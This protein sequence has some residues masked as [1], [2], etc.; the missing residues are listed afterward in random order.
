MLKYCYN[1]QEMEDKMEYLI[2]GNYLMLKIDENFASMT[3]EEIFHYFCL[4]KKAIHLL[5]QYKQYFLNNQYVPM[6]TIVKQGDWLKIS[7]FETG[8]D[9][10]PQ[11]FSLDIVYEDDFL[12]VVNKPCHVIIYPEDKTGSN[13]LCN[14]VAN[15][16]LE[17]D[18]YYPIR[19][20]HRLDKDT[21]GLVLFCK[22]AF[23]QPLLDSMLSKKEIAR[24]Y[25]ALCQGIIDHDIDINLPI[26]R[27]RHTNKMR[28]STSGKQAITHVK[29]LEKNLAGNYTLIECQLETGR[30]H[31]IR[32]HL[33]AISHPL[34]GDR[35]YGKASKLI[36]RTALHGYKLVF[37]HPILNKQLQITAPLPKDFERLKNN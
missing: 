30:K 24:Y 1:N 11:P 4:S 34:I 35:L 37:K 23:L 18:Q 33:Q 29:V 36:N 13:T 10:T 31:Q 25:L 21:T 20:I 3:L 14:Y 7:A 16:Y 15:Y 9:F 19:P 32:V 6:N 2:K 17:T 26:G 8:L 28:I 27:D 22:C 12:L 5:K